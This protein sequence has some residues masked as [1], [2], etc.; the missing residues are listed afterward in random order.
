MIVGLWLALGCG[1]DGSGDDAEASGSSTNAG[2]QTSGPSTSGESTA[3]TESSSLGSTSLP[4]TVGPE[5]SGTQGPEEDTTG[6]TGTVLDVPGGV[7]LWTGAGGGGPGTDLDPD[8]VE[9]LFVD[10]GVDV[11]RGEALPTDFADRFG[12]LV[13]LN[14]T[15][16]FDPAVDTAAIELV[17]SGGRLVLVMEHCKNGCWGNEAGHNALLE[18][19]GSSLRMRGDGGA[20]LS[21][22]PLQLMDVPPLTDGVGELVVYYSGHVEVGTAVALGSM[23]GGDAIIAWEQLGPGEVLAI[24]DS[25]MF[26]YRLDAGD[27]AAFIENLAVH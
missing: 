5:T 8:A 27:N 11:E 1:D 10:A 3:P 9:Q 12:T 13:Y 20:P 18:T 7:F 21:D 14:P 22:T 2:S 6:S 15:G 24:A 4:A 26:G 17:S 25:S 19:L 23:Q 16:D